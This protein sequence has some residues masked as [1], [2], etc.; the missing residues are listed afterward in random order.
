M[1][2]FIA[3]GGPQKIHRAVE[4]GAWFVADVDPRVR[5]RGCQAVNTGESAQ[6]NRFRATTE[7]LRLLR[8]APRRATIGRA[9]FHPDPPVAQQ[10]RQTRKSRIFILITS[11]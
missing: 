4:A 2:R 5:V 8:P 11:Q 9:P 7:P 10:L 3:A 6:A 1:A